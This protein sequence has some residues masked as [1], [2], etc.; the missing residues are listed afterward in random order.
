MVG[1]LAGRRRACLQGH[2]GVA[3]GGFFGFGGNGFEP[4]ALFSS[5]T[6]GLTG[7]PSGPPPWGVYVSVRFGSVVFV[8]RFACGAAIAK[9]VFWSAND[10]TIFVI[11]TKIKRL[12]CLDGLATAPADGLAGLDEA[13][14]PGAGGP[15]G[16]VVSACG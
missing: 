12:A 8:G 13:G 9:N 5:L 2:L 7:P 4:S 11:V 3:P 10:R 16:A 14:G 1:L 6:G 15:V